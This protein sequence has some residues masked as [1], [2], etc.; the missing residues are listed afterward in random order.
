MMLI[1][2]RDSH[3]ADRNQG[4]ICWSD[5]QGWLDTYGGLTWRWR[6]K[7]K[8]GSFALASERRGIDRWII[9]PIRE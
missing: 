6:D 3:D 5:V 4:F 8:K 2:T 7:G 1:V 9:E